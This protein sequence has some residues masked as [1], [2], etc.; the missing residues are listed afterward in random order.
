MGRKDGNKRRSAKKDRLEVRIK[1]RVSE[2]IAQFLRGQAKRS[3]LTINDY[4]RE[5]IRENKP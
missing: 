1:F 3:N 5:L 2:E 4:I